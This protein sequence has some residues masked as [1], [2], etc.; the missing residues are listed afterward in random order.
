MVLQD[1]DIILLKR[2]LDYF[3][4]TFWIVVLLE[5]PTVAEL[6]LL[7]RFRKVFIKNLDIILLS[8]DFLDPD[9]IPCALIREASP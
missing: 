8:H 5:L 6:E 3:S 1:D 7:C 9:G 4:S 2:F